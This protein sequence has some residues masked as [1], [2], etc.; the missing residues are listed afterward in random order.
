M[1]AEL[2]FVQ[3]AVARKDFLP[4]LTHFVIEDG[5]VRGFN[6]TIAISSRI[7]FDIRCKPKADALVRAIGNC[8]DTVQLSLTPAG[9]LSVRSGSFKVFVDCVDGET[10]HVLPEGKYAD[11][12]G[13]ALLAAVIAVQPFIGEDASR[14]W[15]NGILFRGP[16]VFATNNVT[17]VERWVGGNFPATVNVP[18]AAVRELVRINEAPTNI[19]FNDQSLT[20]HY[21]G[22]RWLRTQLLP[23]DWPDLTRILDQPSTQHPVNAELFAGL[24][25]VKPFADKLGRVLFREGSLCTHTAEGE[26]ASYAVEGLP[27]EGAYSIEML[28]LLADTAKTVDFS[29]YPKPCVFYGDK[30]RG[31]IIG[32]RV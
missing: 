5:K 28:E 23:S 22:D 11:I 26:G 27:N 31:V 20:F 21:T 12:D 14:P 3:G 2:K 1:L 24:A 18:R 10:P 7:P 8:K 17:L 30:L 9:R 16:S 6:G 25:V 19:Q 29:T 15:A 13:E 32:M 4:A